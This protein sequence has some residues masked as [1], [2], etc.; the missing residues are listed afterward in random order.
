MPTSFIDRL[1]LLC[2][3]TYDTNEMSVAK[4]ALD[5]LV[6]A[7]E[8]GCCFLE[9]YIVILINF[10][11]K[12]LQ[13]SKNNDNDDADD[14][15]ETMKIK[16]QELLD[17]VLIVDFDRQQLI[18]NFR[19]PEYKL[20]SVEHIIQLLRRVQDL[21]DYRED[22]AISWLSVILDAHFVELAMADEA[23]YIIDQ[24]SAHINFQCALMRQTESTKCLLKSIL[25]HMTTNTRESNSDQVSLI[26]LSSNYRPSQRRPFYTIDQ[27]EF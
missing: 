9:K 12:K 18:E 1:E 22:V 10:C 11:T 8:R 26:S 7:S 24:I 13:K 15:D 20:T 6:K 3:A 19:K 4:Q 17:R 25:E 2:Q 27:I 14:D 21:L 5:M 23:A 16:V